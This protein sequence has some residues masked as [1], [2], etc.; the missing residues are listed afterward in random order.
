MVK[1]KYCDGDVLQELVG[2]VQ[3][4]VEEE[5]SEG[6]EGMKVSN[7]ESC[8]MFHANDDPEHQSPI[9]NPGKSR[10]EGLMTSLMATLRREESTS[11]KVARVD[12]TSVEREK[13]D[14]VH[15]KRCRHR[16]SAADYGCRHGKSLKVE[17]AMSAVCCG[18][19][20]LKDDN[21][22]KEDDCQKKLVVKD[23]KILSYEVRVL[24]SEDTLYST[25][26]CSDLKMGLI[27]S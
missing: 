16:E 22:Q 18:Y 19:G 27:M 6:Q 12:S 24:S 10:T 5:P 11:E 2:D 9:K 8:V 15:R 7:M 13:H 14:V 20:F 1:D 3:L 23:K 4:A 21:Q 17:T 26:S 25:C